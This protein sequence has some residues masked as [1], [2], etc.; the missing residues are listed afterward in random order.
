MSKQTKGLFGRLK[1]ALA[2]KQG[3]GTAER[4]VSK[5]I[6]LPIPVHSRIG[7]GEEE[8]ARLQDI[9]VQGLRLIGGTGG[10][11]GESASIRFDGY[12]GICQSFSLVGKVVRVV[13]E[14][15]GG[16]A[17]EIDRRE[18]P[19]ESLKQYRQLV[20]HYIRHKP[21]LDEV[22]SGLFEGQCESCGWLGHVSA[23]KPCCPRCADEH[24][25][26]VRK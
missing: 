3:E 26:P 11:L 1:G 5:R 2:E 4:R 15:P 9:S 22:D 10:L 24:V 17:I 7:Q 25:V 8:E 23:R 21:L 16:V 20:L 6:E 18:T 13:E 14:E 12:P 19:V